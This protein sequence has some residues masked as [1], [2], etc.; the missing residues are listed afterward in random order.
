MGTRPF[1]GGVTGEGV[2][3]ACKW[4]VSLSLLLCCVV[5][6]A[7]TFGTGFSG[8]DGNGHLGP[9]GSFGGTAAS[10]VLL[11]PARGPR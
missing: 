7:G 5:A 4:S 3:V 9:V 6:L 10:S 1:R 8:D 11:L 2:G